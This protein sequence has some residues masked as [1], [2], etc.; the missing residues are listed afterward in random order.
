MHTYPCPLLGKT[1]PI[2]EIL[3]GSRHVPIGKKDVVCLFCTAPCNR[4]CK[5]YQ[6]GDELIEDTNNPGETFLVVRAK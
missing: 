4:I 2:S 1:L 3:E 6:P 5:T